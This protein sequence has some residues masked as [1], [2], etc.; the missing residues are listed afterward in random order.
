MHDAVGITRLL[1]CAQAEGRARADIDGADLF[2]LI[3]ALGWLDEQPSFSPRADH[4]F[5]FF[6]NA[7]LT[8]AS[9]TAVENL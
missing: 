9:G 3:A 2:A 8:N 1:F 5:G 6:T 7:I 4:L